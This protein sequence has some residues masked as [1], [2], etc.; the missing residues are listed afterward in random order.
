MQT[1][2][3]NDVFSTS[4]NS[5]SESSLE[6]VATGAHDAIDKAAA[7][8]D[9][10]TTKVRPAIERIAATAHQAV[11]KAANAAAPTAD[12]LNQ[13]SES[14]AAAQEKMLSDTRQYVAR[15]PLKT[16]AAAAIAG[17]LIGRL[18]R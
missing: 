5:A 6:H 17:L 2:T 18:L 9:Q 16:V 13:K 4:G 14:L 15:N 1:T 11:D 10:A 8:A 7:A 12:W 3:A